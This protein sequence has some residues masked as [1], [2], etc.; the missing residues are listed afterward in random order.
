M[1]KIFFHTVIVLTLLLVVGCKDDDNNNNNNCVSNEILLAETDSLQFQ[2]E[3]F[4]SITNN[5]KLVTEEDWGVSS[6][7]V[8][9]VFRGVVIILRKVFGSF[10]AAQAPAM[11]RLFEAEAGLD[12]QE[13][14]CWQMESYGFN[15]RS[16][17][18]RGEDVVLSGRVTFPNHKTK[19][20]G[21]QVKSL[22][23]NM[24]HALV[25]VSEAPSQILDMWAL[26]AYF[27]E[28]VIQ[29]D[30][31]GLGVNLDKD[32]Y[33]TVSSNVLARQMA[34]CTMAALEVMRNH[35]VTL[36]DDGHTICTSC[37]LGAAVPLAFAKYYET[38]ASASFRQAVRLSTVYTGF[39]PVDFEGCIRYFSDHPEFN[40]MLSKS[41]VFSLAALSPEQLYGYQAQDFVNPNL[42]NVQVECEGRTMSYYEAEARYFAN[43]IGSDIN[44]PNPKTLSGIIAPDMMTK[45]SHLDSTN[46]KTQVL[47]RILA[48]QNNLSGWLPT[49]EIYLI[50]GKK[51]DGIPVEN[52]RK[53]YEALSNG[54]TMSNVHYHEINALPILSELA[55]L[56]KAGLM[57]LITTMS[58]L[59]TYLKEDPSQ[60]LK[61]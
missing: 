13:D 3:L 19:G 48:E 59:S 49:T 56:P 43:I 25:D 1:R 46:P 35:G 58:F 7:V 36:S 12:K 41:M 38:E 47:L 54:G 18:A 16:K 53:C 37:S 44:M 32:F 28:A 52:M 4:V 55:K 50:H 45:N 57:H 27:N 31:Q 20:I 33:C 34:D 24:H 11:D 29:P 5:G 2:P 15:Y 51:D 22:T 42:L 6:P 39:G 8:T 40:A 30:G 10:I 14:H 61:N 9:N 21:H 23:L 60:E 26:R 17:S